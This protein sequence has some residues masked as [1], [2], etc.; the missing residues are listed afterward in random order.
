MD[1]MIKEKSHILIVDDD[2]N[3]RLSL[4]MI[5]EKAGYCMISDVPTCEEALEIVSRQN[6]DLIFCDI[7]LKGTSGM[8]V[9]RQVKKMGFKC[10]VVMI[11]GAPNDETT[12][13]SERLGAF[14]YMP[15]PVKKD[16]FLHVTHMALQQHN[17]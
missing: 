13:E 1:E 3:L 14:K 6:I 4:K 7:F 15:K 11:T 12:L 5:L 17:S 10:P 8:E 2:E 9:L 16:D